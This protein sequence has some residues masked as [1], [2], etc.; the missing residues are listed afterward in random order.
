MGQD[1]ILRAGWQPALDGLF[2]KRREASYQLAAGCQPCPTIRLAPPLY[3]ASLNNAE[4]G[5]SQS[6]IRHQPEADYS[7]TVVG[8]VNRPA[9]LALFPSIRLRRKCH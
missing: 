4:S 6:S 5:R 9:P 7:E 1:G 8:Q 2:C 3:F